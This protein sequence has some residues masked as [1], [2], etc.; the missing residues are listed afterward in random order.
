MKILGKNFPSPGRKVVGSTPA[1]GSEFFPEDFHCVLIIYFTKLYEQV[2]PM[3]ISLTK[4][5]YI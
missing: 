4:C 2:S 5:K 3:D 1:G